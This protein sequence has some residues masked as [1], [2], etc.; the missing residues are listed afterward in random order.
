MYAYG[1]DIDDI[2][3][4]CDDDDN[5]PVVPNIAAIQKQQAK[6]TAR[7]PNNNISDPMGWK[8]RGARLYM[9]GKQEIF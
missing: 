5:H 4:D 3:D 1:I 9:Q 8:M 6:K 7:L 2:D